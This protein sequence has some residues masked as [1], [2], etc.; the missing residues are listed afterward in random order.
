M[1]SWAHLNATSVLSVFKTETEKIQTKKRKYEWRNRKA[2]AEKAFAG[3]Q[4]FI[5][6][7]KVLKLKCLGSKG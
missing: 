5:W 3:K 2:C 1:V 7:L 4:V 6:H